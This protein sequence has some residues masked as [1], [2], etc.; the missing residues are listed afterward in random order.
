MIW[1]SVIERGRIAVRADRH[2][3]FLVAPV[4]VTPSACSDV[5]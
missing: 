2:V 4:I 5:A 1:P 3:P